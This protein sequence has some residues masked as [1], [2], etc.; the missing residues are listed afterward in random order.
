MFGAGSSITSSNL[1]MM[2]TALQTIGGGGTFNALGGFSVATD[3]DVL[4]NR[5]LLLNGSSSSSVAGKLNVGTNTISGTNNFQTR[6]PQTVSGT[7]ATLTLNSNT[8]VIDPSYYST[9]VNTANVS[10]GL[11]VTGTG[12]QPNTYIIGTNSLNSQITLS[13]PAT[14]AGATALTITGNAPTLATA[15]SG[16][17][18]AT[19]TTNTKS[20]GTNTNYIFNAATVAPF[21]TVSTNPTGNITFNAPVTLNRNVTANGIVTLANGNITIPVSDTLRITSTASLAGANATSYF[22][23]EAN[24]STGGQGALRIDNITTNTLFP[25]G[26][27]SNYLPATVS[28][29]TA[30]DFAAGVFEG[31]TVWNV[32]RINGTGDAALTTNWPQSLEGSTFSSQ[33]NIGIMHHDGTAWGG[34]TGSGN[35][36][37]NTATATFTTFAPFAVGADPATLPMRWKDVSASL[38]NGKVKIGWTTVGEEAIRNYEVE[39]SFNGRNFETIGSITARNS[40]ENSYALIDA[41]PSAVNYY[42]IKSIGLN[43]E[44]KYSSILKVSP[45]KAEVQVY[46]NPAAD[47]ISITGLP[48]KAKVRII[49]MAGVTVQQVQPALNSLVVTMPVASLPKGSYVIQI[50]A[51]EKVETK[52]FQKL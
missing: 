28:P 23:T 12:I 18:D 7:P 5:S 30:S 6:A 20:F 46:P 51:G 34:V 36:A 25:I 1:L 8:V 4:L 29:V 19:V 9:S 27:V 33:F 2:G 43:G 45:G 13:K 16:G 22:V 48:A 39:R 38:I 17:I 41:A 40:V 11:L 10:I 35:N 14:A 44:F 31:I 47:V 3:A 37:T 24:A 49:N 50:E 26:T 42:R 21:S 52:L 15:N 32:T